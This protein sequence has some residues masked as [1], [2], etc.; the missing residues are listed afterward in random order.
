MP[1]LVGF[2][3]NVIDVPVQITVWLAAT[4]TVGAT[5]VV[6]VIT[7]GVLV[8]LGCVRQAA[9]LVIVTVT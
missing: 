8:I 4:A 6:A 9:L 2:A 5:P 7:T 3:V 1:P